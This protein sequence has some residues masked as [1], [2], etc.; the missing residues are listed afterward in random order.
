[1]KKPDT[2][3][4]CVELKE[5][6]QSMLNDTDINDIDK[7]LMKPPSCLPKYKSRQ[8]RHSKRSNTEEDNDCSSNPDVSE[9][10]GYF[11][12]LFHKYEIKVSTIK[13]FM[14]YFFWQQMEPTKRLLP[15][16]V[17]KLK[18]PQ[19]DRFVNEVINVFI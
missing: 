2:K 6:L 4:H 1:M 11:C 19:C 5:K 3:V 18:R 8:S 13:P 16:V 15:I 9:T 7:E 12:C 17:G 14:F 10:E